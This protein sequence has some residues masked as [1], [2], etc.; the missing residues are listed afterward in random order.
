M[1]KEFKHISV[2]PEELVS[3]LQLTPGAKVI[4]CT[5]GGGGHLQKLLEQVGSKGLVIGIDRDPDAIQHLKNKFPKAITSC[6]L[7]LFNEKFSSIRH[8]L[9]SLNISSI[10]GIIADLG[11]SS[12]QIDNRERGFSFQQDGPLDMRMSQNTD[13]TKLSEFLDT[14]SEEKLASIIF[15]YGEEPKA[16]YIARAICEYRDKKPFESTL[17]LATLIAKSIHYKKKSQKHPA[18][19]SFQA[20]RIYLNEELEELEKLLSLSLNLLS[21]KVD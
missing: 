11:V 3:S 21:P 17:E 5:A 4:D 15:R 9:M 6:N 16:R 1:T 2:L 20:F 8:I 18:T 10:D 12:H 19:K 13:Y 7:L 14:V